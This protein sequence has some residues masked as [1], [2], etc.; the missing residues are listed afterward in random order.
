MLEEARALYGGDIV[1]DCPFYGDSAEVEEQRLHL[2]GRATD[3]RVAIGE[4]YEALGDRLAAATAFREALRG[5]PAG[6][7]PAQ[8]GLARLGL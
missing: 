5:E 1:D 6:S 8:A 7:G 3:L 2:R 4:A